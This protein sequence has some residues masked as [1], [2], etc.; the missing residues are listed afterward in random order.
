MCLVILIF[1]S[2]VDPYTARTITTE[3]SSFAEVEQRCYC[4]YLLL[5]IGL[6]IVNILVLIVVLLVVAVKTRKIRQAHFKDT[7]KVNTFLFLLVTVI[8]LT[9]AYWMIFHTIGTKKGYS[10]IT[11]RLVHIIIVASCQG[12]LFVP[13]VLP[14]LQRSVSKTDT[15]SR[16][17]L[18]QTAQKHTLLQSL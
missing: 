11:L 10:D 14:P 7:K 18:L 4:K 8:F 6:L 15:K 1:W 3:Y 13:K 17:T 5:W 12:F 16:G 9:L 2:A